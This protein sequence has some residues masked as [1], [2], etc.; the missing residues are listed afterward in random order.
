[1][2]P[3][4]RVNGIGILVKAVG[5]PSEIKRTREFGF[6]RIGAAPGLGRVRHRFSPA[7]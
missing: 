5:Q 2:A 3:E 6:H 4:R 1:V 7:G